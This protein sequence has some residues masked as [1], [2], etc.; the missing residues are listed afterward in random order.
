MNDT[1]ITKCLESCPHTVSMFV[2]PVDIDTFD[3]TEMVRVKP[4]F[5]DICYLK[6]TFMGFERFGMGEKSI[7]VK[8]NWNPEMFGISINTMIA[9]HFGEGSVVN[10]RQWSSLT[11]KMMDA[12]SPEGYKNHRYVNDEIFAKYME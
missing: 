10:L 2:E 6:Y 12:I 7:V 9:K 5:Y 1:I 3:K 11:E 8:G 4:F